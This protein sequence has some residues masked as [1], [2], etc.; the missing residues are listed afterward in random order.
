MCRT[1]PLRRCIRRAQSSSDTEQRNFCERTVLVSSHA[2]RLRYVLAVCVIGTAGF[3]PIPGGPT[4]S[5][6][7]GCKCGDTALIPE[8]T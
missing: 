5:R 7:L 3:P 2:I 6:L 1:S 8:M 4:T